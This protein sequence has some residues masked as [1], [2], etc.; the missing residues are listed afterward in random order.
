MRSFDIST[1]SQ[2]PDV[3]GEVVVWMASSL[4][5]A[6]TLVPKVLITNPW[7]CLSSNTF[8][9]LNSSITASWRHTGLLD[10]CTNYTPRRRADIQH[11]LNLGQ[12]REN[13]ESEMAPEEGNNSSATITHG[14][15][16]EEESL[17]SHQG[18]HKPLHSP[19][20][21]QSKR[22][23]ELPPRLYSLYPSTATIN[24]L[25]PNT[26]APSTPTQLR[27]GIYHRPP[28]YKPQ[29]LRLPHRRPAPPT[30]NDANRA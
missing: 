21:A 25:S 1:T 2:C 14:S 17:K 4:N 12:R 24:Q 29:V 15:L 20:K 27:K 28:K 3:G 30:P 7:T 9:T 13:N 18:P 16:D 5:G 22:A 6:W 26:S 8:H 10:S 23:S 11:C 19:A